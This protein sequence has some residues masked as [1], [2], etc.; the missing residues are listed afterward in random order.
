VQ[1]GRVFDWNDLRYFLTV[2]RTGS[3][4]A[5]GRELRVS[6][7][8]A[9]RRVAA[10]EA[11]LGLV[12]FERQH[13]GYSLT[14]AGAGLLEA[15]G[16]LEAAAEAVAH[17]AAAQLRELG[18][19]VRITAD[20]VF[21]VTVLTPVLRDLHEAHPAI[22]IELDSTSR[23]RDLGA[24]EADVALRTSKEMT[25]VGVV[26]RRVG[27]GEWAVYCSRAYAAAHGRPETP[28]ELRGRP[29]IGGGGDGVWR[30]YREW[31]RRHALEGAV[32]ME[33]ASAT[34]LLAAVRSGFGLAMLPCFVADVESD[35]IRCVTPDAGNARKLWLLT[36]ERVRS[37]PR[38]RAVVDFLA[39]RLTR[40]S[41]EG[42]RAPDGGLA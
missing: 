29:L 1:N 19:A 24:G 40:L 31:L 8:T 9:A 37:T 38:V 20:E 18:G 2:A 6:Q 12:L 36:H 13:S 35:L 4:L 21:A 32:V 10:L 42:D 3:T 23:L 25:G 28:A 30:V 33:H 22:R 16:A 14:P 7:T 11:S 39:D 17:A 41:R 26:G 15:S 5:A 27:G 34:G